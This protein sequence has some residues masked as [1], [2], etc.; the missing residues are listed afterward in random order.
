MGALLWVTRI[1]TVL[2]AYP[3]NPFVLFRFNELGG[4]SDRLLVPMQN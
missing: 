2:R 1:N 3:N 4:Y